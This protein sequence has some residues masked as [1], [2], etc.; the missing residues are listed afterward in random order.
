[1]SKVFIEGRLQG[2]EL[3]DSALRNSPKP[4]PSVCSPPLPTVVY[5][6][7]ATTDKIAL[8][9]LF[10][11]SMQS[12]V[13]PLRI[14][15]CVSCKCGGVEQRALFWRAYRETERYIVPLVVTSETIIVADTPN[16]E[17]VI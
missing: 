6:L 10:Q 13:N 8:V 15:F 5:S 16:I 11:P 3:R 4:A 9:S 17:Q 12:L 2:F 7:F 1:M 14:V